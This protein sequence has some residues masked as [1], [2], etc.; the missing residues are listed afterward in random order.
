M[1][2]HII[3]ANM[4]A[5]VSLFACTQERPLQSAL[6]QA[7][8]LMTENPDSALA[9]LEKIPSPG[10]MSEEE[11]ALWCLLVTQARDKNYVEHTSDSVIYVA[12]HYYDKKKD[13][14][15]KAQAYYCLGRVL[16][17]LNAPEEALEA[18]LNA[19]EYVQHTADYQLKARINNH[20]G[21]LYWNNR[22]DEES[23]GCYKD[24]CRAYEQC[25]DT[26]GIVNA[27]RNIGKS[28]R[29]LGQLDSAF[30]YF[31]KALQLTN[32]KNILS[33]KAYVLASMGNIY[34]DKGDYDRAL[35]YNKESL[36]YTRRGNTTSARLY[37]IGNLYNMLQMKDSALLYAQQALGSTD[38]HVQ[39]RANQ[40]LY[41][42]YVNSQDYKKAILYNERSLLLKDS[43]EKVHQPLKLTKV[44]ALYNKERFIN[45]QNYQMQEA[46]N[47]R[48]I[49]VICFLCACLVFLSVYF[50]LNRK[51]REQKERINRAFVQLQENENRLVTIRCDIAKK[52]ASLASIQQELKENQQ[53]KDAYYGKMRLLEDGNLKMQEEYGQ[54]L[55][56]IESEKRQLIENTSFLLAEKTALFKQQE[57]LL[58]GQVDK[59]TSLSK[60]KKVIE[61]RFVVLKQE[62]KENQQTK[63][64]YCER[65][66]LLEHKVQLAQGEQELL[67]QQ[68]AD[69]QRDK[70]EQ[71]LQERKAT[72]EER[73]YNSM[74]E[75]WREALIGQNVCLSKIMRKSYFDPF[76][77]EAWDEFERHF[78]MVFPNF[79]DHLN[80]Q[81]SLSE[82]DLRICLL[83]KL[84]LKTAKIAEIFALGPDTITKL[85]SEIREKYFSSF[86]KRS[87]DKILRRWY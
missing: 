24:A 27:L 12:V 57:E 75:K 28:M 40:L 50:Y 35:F 8:R 44:E 54:E 66:R 73:V 3:L 77:A 33:Q 64:T 13:L 71:L 74:F 58:Q 79:A 41:T 48:M 68:Q 17:D 5:I 22:K 83:V 14:K 69:L 10:E 52:E 60:E 49:L 87:L 65:I 76:N 47:Q 85:K 84:G 72:E 61:E 11:Y 78:E 7:E 6:L 81:Y 15:R 21:S 70:K 51:I 82:R 34:G 43:I 59:L 25:A 86:E 67:R 45:K 42:L 1:R 4:L 46:K 32:Q 62:L 55:S 2:T 31:E 18:F 20:L 36:K 63:D 53:A 9:V 30:L 26:V 23:L 19:K 39:C 29:G 37:A 80:E 56:R 38:L 16:S